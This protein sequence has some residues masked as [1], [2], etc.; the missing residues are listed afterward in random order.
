MVKFVIFAYQNVMRGIL[1]EEI[2]FE[3]E[4]DATLKRNS[5][6]E[7]E[8]KE[9]NKRMILY[10]KHVKSGE[11]NKLDNKKKLHVHANGQVI[12]MV[13]FYD[14]YFTPLGIQKEIFPYELK[15]Y[16]GGKCFEYSHAQ[17]NF[18]GLYTWLK[19]IKC[20]WNEETPNDKLTE[21]ILIDDYLKEKTYVRVIKKNVL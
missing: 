6:M 16:I 7:Q 10:V 19:Y 14:Y 3:K 15:V 5:Y 12:P 21:I 11:L 8:I 20:I 4:S 1:I 13:D 17:N 2:L 9:Y 18:R